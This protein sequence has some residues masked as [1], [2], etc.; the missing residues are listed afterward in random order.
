M[1]AAPGSVWRWV[2]AGL[3]AYVA[4]SEAVAIYLGL[5]LAD[6]PQVWLIA[7]ESASMLAALMAVAA[8]LGRTHGRAFALAAAL[9]QAAS[10]FAGE[11]WMR[12]MLAHFDALMAAYPA[13]AKALGPIGDEMRAALAS[14]AHLLEFAA[15]LAVV[16][17]VA[18]AAGKLRTEE[19]R[20]H[21]AAH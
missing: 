9:V 7:V 18:L 20:R 21:D 5:R 12:S 6:D 14:P 2:L 10:V 16:L 17:A 15:Q 1:E 11:L 19:A 3:L 4:L 8:V 13:G